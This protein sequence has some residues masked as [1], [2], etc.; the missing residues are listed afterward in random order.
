MT[1]EQVAKGEAAPPKKEEK[2][3]LGYLER[4][5]QRIR[6]KVLKIK[7]D[8]LAIADSTPDDVKRLDQLPKDSYELALRKQF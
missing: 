7:L 6:E 1:D 8:A 5:Q 4:R 3:D 2:L